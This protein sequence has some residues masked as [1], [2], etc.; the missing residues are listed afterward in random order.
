MV[1]LVT[2]M[3]E[4]VLSETVGRALVT[5]GRVVE[6]EEVTLTGRETL[7]ELGTTALLLLLSVVSVEVVTMLDD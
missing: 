7:V 3:S 6:L 2:L 1:V 4:E 5:T